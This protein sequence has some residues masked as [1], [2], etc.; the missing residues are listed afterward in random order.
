MISVS[1]SIPTL[2]TSVLEG[3]ELNR[4]VIDFVKVLLFYQ[5]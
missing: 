2:M 5:F 3:S 1:S 4:L